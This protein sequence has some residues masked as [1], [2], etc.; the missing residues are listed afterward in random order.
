[1]QG[2]PFVYEA[3]LQMLRPLPARYVSDFTAQ[4][5]RSCRLEL[6]GRRDNRVHQRMIEARKRLNE[7]RR[8]NSCVTCVLREQS[9][10][11]ASNADASA[12]KPSDA[13]SRTSSN[14]GTRNG[15]R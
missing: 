11:P 1:M 6:A 7:V 12:L 13:E 15:L 14:F 3:G 5:A 2:R 8:S 4:D 10:I 9:A